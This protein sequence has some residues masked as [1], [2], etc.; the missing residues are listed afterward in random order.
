MTEANKKGYIFTP[1]SQI[2]CKTPQGYTI[3]SHIIS[4]HELWLKNVPVKHCWDTFQ[5]AWGLFPSLDSFFTLPVMDRLSPPSCLRCWRADWW[6][7]HW[8]GSS[9]SRWREESAADKQS[10][11]R[12]CWCMTQS[13]TRTRMACV[14]SSERHLTQQQHSYPSVINN[15]NKINQL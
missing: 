1:F 9:S 15:N 13:A 8:C 14:P 5:K 12:P 4:C 10:P 3:Y 2:L 6:C 7:R 11:L